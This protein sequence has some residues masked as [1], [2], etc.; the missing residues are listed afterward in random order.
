[1]SRVSPADQAYLSHAN[2]Y[3]SSKFSRCLRRLYMPFNFS[4]PEF[5]SHHKMRKNRVSSVSRASPAHMN[6]P[7]VVLIVRLTVI[8]LN[9]NVNL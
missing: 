9:D 1:M 2:L 3:F 4:S 7:L 5:L 6:S 8:L